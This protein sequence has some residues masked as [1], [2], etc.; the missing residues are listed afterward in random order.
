MQNDALRALIARSIDYAGLFPPA[1]L[2]LEEALRNH[3][4]Y[5][6][7]PDVWMLGTFVLPTAKFFPA[8]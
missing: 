5:V 8:K 1:S 4:A 2:P 6:R 7:D 3:A